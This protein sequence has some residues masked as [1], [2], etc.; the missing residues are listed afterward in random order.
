MEAAIGAG[1]SLERRAMDRVLDSAELEYI[2]ITVIDSRHLQM[3]L[4]RALESDGAERLVDSL[5][6]SGMVDRLLERLSTSDALWQLIDVI[7]ASPTVT[8]AISQQ[9]LGFADQVGEEARKRSKDADDWLERNAHRL[10]RR[11]RKHLPPEPEPN[12]G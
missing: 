4:R 3:V 2:L 5:F 7:A 12:P 9:G 11:P 8:A 6:D 10:L 1:I